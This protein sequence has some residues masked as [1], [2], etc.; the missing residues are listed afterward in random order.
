MLRVYRDEFWLYRSPKVEID[1]SYVWWFDRGWAFYSLGRPASAEESWKGALGKLRA[2]PGT[3]IDQARCLANLGNV[4]LSTGQFSQAEDH[5]R[6]ALRAFQAIRGTKI[7]QARCL[8]GLGILYL[9]TQREHEARQAA[10]GALEI[11]ERYPAGTGPIR[12]ACLTI[13]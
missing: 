3:E 13:L 4:Y 2:I 5:L 10:L 11:C 7:D 6:E 1:D 8:L 12:E 9:A